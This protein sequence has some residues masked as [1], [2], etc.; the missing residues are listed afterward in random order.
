MHNVPVNVRPSEVRSLGGDL[1]AGG[2]WFGIYGEADVRSV[3][4]GSGDCQQV[5]FPGGVFHWDRR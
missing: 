2:Q 3:Y 5:Q 4:D 1:P